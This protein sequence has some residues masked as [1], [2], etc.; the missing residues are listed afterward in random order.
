MGYILDDRYAHRWRNLALLYVSQWTSCSRISICS[1]RWLIDETSEQA[2][3][4]RDLWKALSNIFVT[5]FF[6]NVQYYHFR[7]PHLHIIVW[8]FNTPYRLTEPRRRIDVTPREEGINE[9]KGSDVRNTFEC[10]KKHLR[11]ERARM[12]IFKHQSQVWLA[13]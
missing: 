5:A 4:F 6:T 12:Q 13:Y 9:T 7:N 10:R 11:M 3:I 2:R 1:I 8:Q